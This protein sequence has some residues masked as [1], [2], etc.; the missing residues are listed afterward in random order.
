MSQENNNTNEDDNQELRFYPQFKWE[1]HCKPFFKL[2][3][4]TSDPVFLMTMKWVTPTEGEI[5]FLNDD[6]EPIEP[7]FKTENKNKFM[8]LLYNFA[9]YETVFEELKDLSYKF[10]PSPKNYGLFVSR[11]PVE[12]SENYARPAKAGFFAYVEPDVKI[13]FKN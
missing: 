4:C 1:K 7:N 6:Y 5:L 10:E 11:Y 3:N 8:K 2:L 13:Y 9:K 12:V